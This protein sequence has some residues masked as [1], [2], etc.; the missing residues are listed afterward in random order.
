MN[1]EKICIITD[2]RLEKQR[3]IKKAYINGYEQCM[4]DFV[5]REDPKYTFQSIYAV[6]AENRNLQ[7]TIDSL[8]KRISY[9]E[10]SARNERMAHETTVKTYVKGM[11]QFEEENK[12]LKSQII[13]LKYSATIVD[14]MQEKIEHLRQDNNNL[15]KENQELKK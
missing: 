1:S 2:T 3:F 6:E 4:T 11:M 9:Q 10:D 7:D 5:R 13:C 8:K 15:K 14:A 12:G